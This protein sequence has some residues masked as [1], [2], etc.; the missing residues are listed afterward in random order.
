MRNIL[1]NAAFRQKKKHMEQNQLGVTLTSF[2]AI[3]TLIKYTITTF[4]ATKWVKVP[5]N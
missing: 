2:I 1:I 4:P 3:S 5:N